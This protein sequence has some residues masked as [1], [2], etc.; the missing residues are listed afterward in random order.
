[1]IGAGMAGLSAATVLAEAGHQVTIFDKG[2]KPGG[3]VAARKADGF[4]FNHGCQFASARDSRFLALLDSAG[5]RLWPRAGGQ[6]FAGVPDM[7]RIPAHL[8]AP[9]GGDLRQNVHVGF[10]EQGGSGWVLS[11]YDAAAT[12]PGFVGRGGDA[13]GPFDAV[14]L[15]IPAPQAR[16][17]LAA[18]GHGFGAALEAVHIAPCWALMLGFEGPVAGPDTA[19]P[20]SG[21]IGWLARE[22]SRPGAAPA[23][24]AYTIHACAGWSAAHLEESAGFV[25]AELSAVFAAATGIA[26][27]PVYAKAHRW[28]YALADRPLGE[29][30]L[31]DP[32]VQLGL[33]G[34]WCLGGKLEAAYLSGH[35]LGILAAG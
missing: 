34:D 4:T 6:R 26:A 25:T 18:A 17:L 29:T 33:C 2:R 1:M 14:I 35:A 12:S 27:A 23:P 20:D 7:A 10:I 13:A 22:N 9:F 30:H 5:A 11:L 24:V 16:N 19:K 3:R 21:P 15:A 31:W 8:A 32:A 28:R